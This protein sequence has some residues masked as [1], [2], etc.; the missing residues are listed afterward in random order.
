MV[1]CFIEICQVIL[2]SVRADGQ[3]DTASHVCL[4]TVAT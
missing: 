2:E 3:T 1:I 4:S